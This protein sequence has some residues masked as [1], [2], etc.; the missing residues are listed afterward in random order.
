MWWLGEKTA[1]H[2]TSWLEFCTNSYYNPEAKLSLDQKILYHL[3]KFKSSTFSTQI[4]QIN[5][6]VAFHVHLAQDTSQ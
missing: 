6:A 3:S 2:M 5:L 4:M 1:S